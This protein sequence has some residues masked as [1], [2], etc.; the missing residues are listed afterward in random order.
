MRLCLAWY[1]QETSRVSNYPLDKS[2][3]KGIMFCARL[4]LWNRSQPEP[5]GVGKKI[6]KL[7]A[8]S[9]RDSNEK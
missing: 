2:G 4:V 8:G 3:R 7:E 5:K 1:Q 9:E 6:V